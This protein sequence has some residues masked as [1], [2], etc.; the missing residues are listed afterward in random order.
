M[1]AT[2][3]ALSNSDKSRRTPTRDPV[4]NSILALSLAVVLLWL[5]LA[6]SETIIFVAR[7]EWAALVFWAVLV[8]VAN[9]FPIW[10]GEAPQVTLTL[11][12]PLMVA[13]ALLYPPEVAASLALVAAIDIR[14]LGLRV[15]L[16]RI[17]FN[18]VQ[19]ALTAWVASQ[20]FHLLASGL[21]PWPRAILATLG[22]V[23][24]SYGLNILL[25]SAY[26]GL[27]LGVGPLSV[28]Q[29]L[30]VGGRVQ[31]LATYLGYCAMALVL[32]RLFTDVGEWS[33]I[34]FLVPIAAAQQM[35]V[36]GQMLHSLA[37]ELRNRERLLERLSERIVE[38]R[39]DER[40]R[41]ASDL[42]DRVLQ[43][44]VKIGMSAGLVGRALPAENAAR[45]DVDE[46]LDDTAFS[47]EEL[48]RVIHDL[49]RSPLGPGG[50]SPTLRG[51]ARDLQLDWGV[52]ITVSAPNELS[53][54][55]ETQTALYQIARECVLNA[56]KH[57]EASEIGVSLRETA[58]EAEL[59]AEDDGIGFD[60][61]SVDPSRHFGLG[62][63]KERVRM[64]GGSIAIDSQPGRTMVSVRI[65]RRGREEGNGLERQQS[66]E[67]RF[68][69]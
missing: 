21:E 18:R 16:I 22:A 13:T 36:R 46:L 5:L 28:I 65:P 29:R 31:F 52:R 69:D 55:A 30:R 1:S 3:A 17:V 58:S 54:S 24:A 37:T 8:F 40:I 57:A 45:H 26:T 20:T 12:M 64:A 59:E 39:R 66:S 38:E 10:V 27:R 61:N 2:A 25:V 6:Q 60:V 43:C 50:L 32:A 7:R 47:V 62:L 53:L 23:G 41:I 44:L 35:L 9:L 33:V 51:L 68:S 15:P 48:R 49:Q 4:R 19:V 34:S 63:M 67:M 42:H 14:E 56:L 11:D